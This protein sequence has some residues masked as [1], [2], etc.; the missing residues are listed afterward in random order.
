MSLVCCIVGYGSYNPQQSNFGLAQPA[1]QGA[2][3]SQA[4]TSPAKG[5]GSQGG[6]GSQHSP[7]FE[8]QSNTGGYSSQPSPGY[9]TQQGTQFGGYGGGAAPAASGQLTPSKAS[10]PAGPGVAAGLIKPT[11]VVYAPCAHRLKTPVRIVIGWLMTGDLLQASFNIKLTIGGVIELDFSTDS[12]ISCHP[13]IS[14]EDSVPKDMQH[15]LHKCSHVLH[16]LE[17]NVFIAGDE[18]AREIA[19]RG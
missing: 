3:F 8:A 9:S 10:V 5:Y 4:A 13:I 2:G 12:K 15:S 16:V 7:G 19:V 1:F 11:N 17:D 14:N 18:V 6:F